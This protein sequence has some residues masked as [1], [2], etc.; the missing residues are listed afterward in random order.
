MKTHT[1]GRLILT[2]VFITSFLNTFLISSVNVALPII[3]KELDLNAVETSL[4]ITTYLLSTAILLLPAGR[5]ADLI[6]LGF[7]FKLGI[8]IFTVASLGCYFVHNYS[9]LLIFRFLQGIGAAFTS[10]TGPALLTLHFPAKHRGRVLGYS[11]SAVYVG[12]G[13]GPFIGGY[14][15]DFFGWKSLFLVVSIV[16][17][18]LSLF[19]LK[20]KFE[21][22]PTIGKLKGMSYQ[23][24]LVY[25]FGLSMLVIGSAYIPQ[26]WAFALT[27]IGTAL[28]ILFWHV[29]KRAKT[30]IL[31]VNLFKTNRLFSYSNLA[32]LINYSATYALVFLMSLFLQKI[33]FLTPRKTGVILMT[34]PIV[35]ALFSP[36]MGRI[37]DHV[38]PRI[39]TTLGMAICSIGLFLFASLTTE[40][41]QLHIIL[42]LAWMGIGFALFS[43]PNMNTIMGSVEKSK[44]GVAS[45]TA[46]TMRVFGQVLSMTMASLS[47]AF[48]LGNQT[49]EKIEPAQFHQT[50]SLT[51]SLFGILSLAGI[52]FS[53]A[54]GNR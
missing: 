17:F 4:I 32:A 47:F 53:Y 44:Y 10:T 45:G 11:V 6:G 30:P 21:T 18:V 33:Q 37:S 25:V 2:L 39:L 24:S 34:Q 51:L 40:S 22:S 31:E 12:L 42:L 48:F 41:S 1:Q 26:N 16:G 54:R 38:Q 52:Y 13:T 3:A 50:Y 28:L 49:M 7:L 46:A 27:I 35:M 36:I 19:G 8:L 43:S 5:F 9:T 15:T 20:I 14:L 29:E 23:G